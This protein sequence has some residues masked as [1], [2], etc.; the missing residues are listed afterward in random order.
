M[1]VRKL[2]SKV[3]TALLCLMV[4]VLF[5]MTFVPGTCRY[6]SDGPVFIVNKG[7]NF[8]N[9]D[10]VFLPLSGILTGISLLILIAS[11]AGRSYRRLTTAAV[12]L[13]LA[14]MIC[15]YTPILQAAYYFQNRHLDVAT[16]WVPVYAVG[17]F[18]ASV[19]AFV[20]R[21]KLA[22]PVPEVV[23]SKKQMALYSLVIAVLFALCYGKICW[24]N[25]FPDFNPKFGY[26]VYYLDPVS[27][28]SGHLTLIA[29]NLAL[30]YSFGLLRGRPTVCAVLLYA[31]DALTLAMV[32]LMWSRYYI[33]LP[34]TFFMLAA[35]FAIGLRFLLGKR[36]TNQDQ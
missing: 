14:A 24:K 18:S 11:L 9:A 7:V 29:L 22:E 30:L 33:P 31:A 36:K 28:L 35:Q 19:L 3:L 10:D 26:D 21:S 16:F 13:E 34:R 25:V 8:Y 32:C 12:L 23:F 17:A 6:S 1:G 5:A 15:T 2:N 27:W 4:A 20:V